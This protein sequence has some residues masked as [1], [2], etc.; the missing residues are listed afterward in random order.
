ME[1][2]KGKI[3]SHPA[4]DIPYW[5]TKVYSDMPVYVC[6]IKYI[7]VLFWTS[8]SRINISNIKKYCVPLPI[9]YLIANNLI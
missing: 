3:T 5:L 4:G 8:V 6:F 7:F 1:R 9:L 2:P